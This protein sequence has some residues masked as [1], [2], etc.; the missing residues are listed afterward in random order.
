MSIAVKNRI[1]KSE[2]SKKVHEDKKSLNPNQI[3]LPL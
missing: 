1:T 3:T 2:N